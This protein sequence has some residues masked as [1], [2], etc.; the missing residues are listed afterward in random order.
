M[1]WLSQQLSASLSFVKII[2]MSNRYILWTTPWLV[3]RDE[4]RGWRRAG[5]ENRGA[6]LLSAPYR[7]SVLLVAII[8]VHSNSRRNRE[9][10]RAMV[11]V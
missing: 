10:N 8:T 4:R 5:G 7:S 6:T 11:G 3:T 1:N 2:R 9:T